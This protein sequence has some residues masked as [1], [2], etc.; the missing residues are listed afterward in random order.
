MKHQRYFL[1]RI[2][3]PTWKDFCIRVGGAA[4]VLTA[5]ILAAREFFPNQVGSI[6]VVVSVGLIVVVGVQDWRQQKAQRERRKK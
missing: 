4:G 6:V 1:G 3:N 5:V 2:E